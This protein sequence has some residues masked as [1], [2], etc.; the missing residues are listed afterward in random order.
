MYATTAIGGD[1]RTSPNADERRRTPGAGLTMAVVNNVKVAGPIS[2]YGG[3][4]AVKHHVG[5]GNQARLNAITPQQQ[6]L[7]AGIYR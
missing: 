4:V 5:R 6:R 3:V 1:A 2:D 7:A